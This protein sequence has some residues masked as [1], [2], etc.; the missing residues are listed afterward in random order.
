MDIES[1]MILIAG[2][3]LDWIMFLGMISGVGNQLGLKHWW[4]S[5]ASCLRFV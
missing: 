4:I 1:F 5:K 3:M 2:W